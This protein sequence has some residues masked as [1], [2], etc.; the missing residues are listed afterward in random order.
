[1]N[2]KNIRTSEV[3]SFIGEVFIEEL[4]Y[5]IGEDDLKEFWVKNNGVNSRAASKDVIDVTNYSY[6]TENDLKEAIFIHLGRNSIYHLLPEAF[7]HPLVISNPNMSNKEVVE[8]IRKNRRTEQENIRFFIPFDTEFFKKK[9]SLV[10]RYLNI[11]TDPNAKYNLFTLARDI[12]AKDLSL[13]KEQLYK[14]FLN[15]CFSEKLKE[16]LPALSNLL[17][18][19]MDCTIT[20]KYVPKEHSKT[21]FKNLGEGILGHNAGLQGKVVSEFDDVEVTMIA[22]NQM[23]H[24]TIQEY[25]KTIKGILEFFLFANRDIHVR[26]QTYG[27]DEFV[28]GENFLGYNTAIPIVE[29]AFDEH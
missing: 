7:F 25:M 11:F 19:I 29:E 24:Q 10:N 15:L 3:S 13:N 4:K 16:N 9:V 2:I 18:N 12:I 17:T 21:P 26:Y 8:A 1:M 6:A 23:Q 14:L 28:L 27:T 5:I 20:I 22:Q